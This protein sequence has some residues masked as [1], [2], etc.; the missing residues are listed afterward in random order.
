MCLWQANWQQKYWWSVPP[1]ARSVP[2]YIALK[3]G[4]DARKMGLDATVNQLKGAIE[5]GFC[6]SV[7]GLLPW[8]VSHFITTKGI[9]WGVHGPRKVATKIFCK[10][11]GVPQLLFTFFL[12]GRNLCNIVP[13]WAPS[14]KWVPK[15]LSSVVSPW[16]VSPRVRN[17]P[18]PRKI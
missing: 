8:Q 13:R 6:A 18:P 5:H 15:K 12:G 3:M 7:V 9:F 4:L 16:R 1:L 2:G 14:L 17:A 11:I 10:P